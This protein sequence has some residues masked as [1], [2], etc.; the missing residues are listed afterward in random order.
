MYSSHILGA[1]GVPYV[2]I[3]KLK[4]ILYRCIDPLGLLVSL[5]RGHSAVQAWVRNGWIKHRA[6]TKG[7]RGHPIFHSMTE[8]LSRFAVCSLLHPSTI[9]TLPKSKPGSIGAPTLR[10]RAQPRS[11]DHR[12]MNSNTAC[13]RTN[14]PQSSGYPSPKCACWILPA[15]WNLT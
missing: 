2:G 5:V 8:W 13:P 11:P 14:E 3:S 15:L 12:E 7:L 1:Q 4:F 9:K 6:M 10:Q